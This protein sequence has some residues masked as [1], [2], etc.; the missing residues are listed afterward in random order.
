MHPE[1]RFFKAADDL[2]A[3]DDDL[4]RRA[5]LTRVMDDPAIW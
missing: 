3:P 1:Q 2:R 4:D 5:T